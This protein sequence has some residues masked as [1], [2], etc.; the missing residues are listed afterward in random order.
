MAPSTPRCALRN[1]AQ[2]ILSLRAGAGSMPCSRRTRWTPGANVFNPIA[3]VQMRAFLTDSAGQWQC[4]DVASGLNRDS[5][6]MQ[7]Y[8]CHGGPNQQWLFSNP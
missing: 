2:G 5:L 1:V 3:Q 8:H 4:V 6:W 7:T